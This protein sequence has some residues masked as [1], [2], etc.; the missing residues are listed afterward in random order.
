MPKS[1][2]ID[3]LPESA[4]SHRS[5]SAVVAVDVIRATTLAVT[6]VALGR[7]CFPVPSLDAVLRLA[8]TLPDALLAGEIG[9]EMPPGMHMNNSPAALAR[10]ADVARPLIMVSSS[11]TRLI[12]NALGCGALYLGCFRNASAVAARLIED[13][14][15][16]IVLLG[17]GSRGEFREEDQICCAWIAARLVRAGYQPE[18][19]ATVK[20]IHRW[21]ASRAGDCL[22]SRSVDY[23]ARTDQLA[24][25]RFILQHVNDLD[26]AFIVKD[27][28][29]RMIPGNLRIECRSNSEYP[30]LLPLVTLG[31]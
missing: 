11:G 15:S 23:L 4:A 24:D 3:S 29:V 7:R 22:I 19:A 27:G 28:E 2:L 25:L 21:A 8:S 6:A 13:G 12:A 5:G 1:F 14:H 16:R 10:R 17:A 9:G 26:S 20:I 31:R 30:V 18:N